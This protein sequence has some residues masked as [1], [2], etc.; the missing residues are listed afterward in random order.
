MC[1]KDRLAKI[2]KKNRPNDNWDTGVA[3]GYA[4]AVLDV[5]RPLKA[6]GEIETIGKFL[7]DCGYFD[8]GPEHWIRWM[9]CDEETK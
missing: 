6:T 1:N 2:F 9:Y 7:A 5:A 4:Q 8:D 3:L